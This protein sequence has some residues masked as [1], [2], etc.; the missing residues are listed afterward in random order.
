MKFLNTLLLTLSTFVATSTAIQSIYVGY[1]SSGNTDKCGSYYA[2]FSDADPCTSGVSVN[3]YYCFNSGSLCTPSSVS[4]LGHGG[5]RFIGCPTSGPAS[6]KFPTGVLDA[7]NTNVNSPNLVCSTNGADGPYG[8][9]LTNL[10]FS[11]PAN[12]LPG[13]PYGFTVYGVKYCK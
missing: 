7:P 1:R 11:C 13:T 2:W 12:S 9:D 4:I 8:P 6:G 10:K 5:I 3:S